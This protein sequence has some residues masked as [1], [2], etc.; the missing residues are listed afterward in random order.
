MA[1]AAM[2]DGEL[3]WDVV[4]DFLRAEPER[5]RTD[6]ALLDALGLKVNHPNIVDF[7][8]AALSRLEQAKQREA[9]TREAIEAVARANYAAQA[10]THAA[11]LDLLSARNHA[12][13]ARLVDDAA[14][15][16]FGLE[17]GVLAVEGPGGTPAGWHALEDGV[18][19]AVL[20][21]ESLSRMGPVEDPTGVFGERGARVKSVA[22]VRIS[23]WDP[24]RDGVLAFG[25]PDP[26]GFTPT[27]GS[28][29]VAF[30]SRV[31]E[32]TAERW[33]VL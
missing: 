16:R 21:P 12:D 24:A 9:E 11:V 19:D 5:L 30:L 1:G 23:L 33:P 15:L 29:L 3:D 17:A 13:L 31:V 32:R 28:E 27:M 26:Q 14:R 8:Q 20:G 22:L 10:Q 2:Q 7:T 4:R 25:S 6:D 18:V